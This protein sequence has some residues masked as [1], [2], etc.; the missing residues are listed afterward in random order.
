MTLSEIKEA[1]SH[2]QLSL[3]KDISENL[4]E[5]KEAA[6]SSKNEALANEIWCVNQIAKIQGLYIQFFNQIKSKKFEDSWLILERSTIRSQ[7]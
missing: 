3:N 7:A 6:I 5:L 4:M 2:Q 1:L